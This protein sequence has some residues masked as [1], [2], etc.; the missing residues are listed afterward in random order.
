MD[1]LNRQHRTPFFKQMNYSSL[2]EDAKEMCRPL[3]DQES[4]RKD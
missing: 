3:L 2:N 4:E 1:I